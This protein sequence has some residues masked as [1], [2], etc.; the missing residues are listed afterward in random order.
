MMEK[1]QGQLSIKKVSQYKKRVG[2]R[3]VRI[4][5][6]QK[7]RRTSKSNEPSRVAYSRS[8]FGR[9]GYRGR[10]DTNKVQFFDKFG[11][12]VRPLITYLDMR[13]M[14]LP[15]RTRRAILRANSDAGY[16]RKR[17]SEIRK[18]LWTIVSTGK[19]LLWINV[20][21]F[22]YCISGISK[23]IFNGRKIPFRG[24][25]SRRYKKILGLPQSSLNVA[26]YILDVRRREV[27]R[28]RQGVRQLMYRRAYGRKL[29]KRG[30]VKLGWRHSRG[31]KIRTRRVLIEP[32]GF[33]KRAF[34][35]RRKNAIV[36]GMRRVIGLEDLR[37]YKQKLIVLKRNFRN[38]LSV[39]FSA[40]EY[41]L[42][43][44]TRY[45]S[46]AHKQGRLESFISRIEQK[47]V[48]ILARI[49]QYAPRHRTV[50]LLCE[51]VGRG[52]L[53]INGETTS[54][55]HYHIE[56]L[57]LLE[58][59]YTYYFVE[60]QY[61]R[62][63]VR[64]KLPFFFFRQKRPTRLWRYGPLVDKIIHLWVAYTQGI[65]TKEMRDIYFLFR[66][67]PKLSWLRRRSRRSRGSNVRR[68][69]KGF[70]IKGLSNKNIKTIRSVLI[71]LRRRRR[72]K[73]FF[74][75]VP[76]RLRKRRVSRSMGAFSHLI[77][78]NQLPF[79][80]FRQRVKN[81]GQSW[82]EFSQMCISVIIFRFQV[83]E[84]L[85]LRRFTRKNI[86]ALMLFGGGL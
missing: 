40:P 56:N 8:P 20:H 33:R 61:H 42:L 75:H 60:K 63:L 79:R 65:K 21:G 28:C 50:A 11:K 32:R 25:G 36:A 64:K 16:S 39:V 46:P 19:K 29:K 52:T 74:A 45:F 13:W 70:L 38:S 7:Q 73:R 18:L 17:L 78:R 41:N 54:D 49:P 3:P 80:H 86:S 76:K 59:N 77:P 5:R 30:R 24:W 48:F 31:R 34:M 2:P 55:V 15:K 53:T 69:G 58:Y 10:K 66:K 85:P 35:R 6:A 83:L 67:H 57:D 4:I 26:A 51:L 82:Y 22:W 23:M 47:L 68:Q 9:K 72:L 62:E 44:T 1:K 81:N 37:Q 27:F 43:L 84:D 12:Q 14:V 71:K